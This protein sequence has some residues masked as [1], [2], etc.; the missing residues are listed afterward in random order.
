MFDEY[1]KKVNQV[2]Q[3]VV[4][5]KFIEATQK[6][7]EYGNREFLR[8]FQ[9]RAEIINGKE[10]TT[11]SNNNNNAN[12]INNIDITSLILPFQTIGFLETKWLEVL[13][14]LIEYGNNNILGSLKLYLAVAEKGQ[15]QEEIPAGVKE[16]FSGILDLKKEERGTGIGI[17]IGIE[18]ERAQNNG[19]NHYF[20][21]S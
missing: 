16:V 13:K 10:Q 5:S 18:K 6:L 9:L 2:S 14:E 4:E 3:F 19:S 8:S 11:P 21:Q 15:Q 7:V 20:A 12:S 17:G 1:S